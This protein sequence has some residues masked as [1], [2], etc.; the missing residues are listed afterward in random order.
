M[1]LD[2]LRLPIEALVKTMDPAAFGGDVWRYFAKFSAQQ[3]I[4]G[5][6]AR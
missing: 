5:K 3:D 4:A 6:K 1:L 2:S